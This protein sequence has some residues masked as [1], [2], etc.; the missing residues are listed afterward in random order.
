[1]EPL[2]FSIAPGLPAPQLGGLPGVR[3]TEVERRE[4]LKESR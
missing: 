4:R 2:L 1:M 3:D